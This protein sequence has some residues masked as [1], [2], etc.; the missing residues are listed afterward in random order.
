MER[1]VVNVHH[2]CQPA[3]PSPRDRLKSTNLRSRGPSLSGNRHTKKGETRLANR[4]KMKQEELKRRVAEQQ[5]A[6]ESQNADPVA[7]KKTYTEMD[8][9]CSEDMLDFASEQEFP[10][11]TSDDLRYEDGRVLSDKFK[12]EKRRRVVRLLR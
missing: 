10:W 12:K 4:L 3:A 7:E 11:R 2:R 1:V 9:W 6:L 8:D 5:Q